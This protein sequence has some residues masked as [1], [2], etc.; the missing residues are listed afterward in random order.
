MNSKVWNSIV[1]KDYKSKP[2]TLYNFSRKKLIGKEYPGILREEGHQVKGLL[3]LDIELDDL[4]RLDE[5]EGEEFERI[6][7]KVDDYS[8]DTY[9]FVGNTELISSEEWLPYENSHR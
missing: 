7:M 6:T 4:I 8:I 2:F 9:L 3:Y 5:Y 1:A